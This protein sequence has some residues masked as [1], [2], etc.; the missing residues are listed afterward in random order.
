V[1]QV[2]GEEWDN[3]RLQLQELIRQSR[4]HP[5]IFVWGLHNEVYGKQGF[6][7]APALT[8]ELHLLAKH[9]DPWRPTIS[10]TGSGTPVQPV[11]YI[12]DLQGV[13]RYYG[14]YEGS[15]PSKLEAWIEKMDAERPDNRIALSEYGAEANV[16]QQADAIPVPFPD[17]VKGQFYPEIV[18]T[19]LHEVQWSILERHPEIW[20]TYL[21]NLCDFTVPLWNRGGVPGR[22]MKGLVTYDRAIKKD[23]FHWYR[24]NW[25]QGPAV[26]VADLRIPRHAGKAFDL[27]VYANRPGVVLLVDGAEVAGLQPGVNGRHF[28]ARGLVLPKG[29]HR[30]EARLPA[31][32]GAPAAV[33]SGE[34]VVGE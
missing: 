23:A 3:A 17:P 32:G 7:T 6:D 30:V 33:A 25:S 19:R 11:T 22:N 12:A 27:P 9:E 15:D 26:H 21:W 4:N 16:A 24:V 8:R 13:N 10:V 20:G 5:S 28:W 29:T 1:N 2:T 18:Q 31:D 34:I 14:W